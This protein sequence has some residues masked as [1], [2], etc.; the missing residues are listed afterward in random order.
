ML[1]GAVFLLEFKPEDNP[2]WKSNRIMNHLMELDYVK[3]VTLAGGAQAAFEVTVTVKPNDQYAGIQ[4]ME[5]EINRKF[6][7]ALDGCFL[8]EVFRMDKTLKGSWIVSEAPKRHCKYFRVVN[9]HTGEPV[10]L[11][12]EFLI[13]AITK[14]KEMIASLSKRQNRV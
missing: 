8:G 3:E 1:V 14:D 5:I 12:R 4:A 6:A 10:N 11:D 2:C 7:S 9:K 13:D